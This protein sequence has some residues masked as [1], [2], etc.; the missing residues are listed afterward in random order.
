MRRSSYRILQQ[1]LEGTQSEEEEPLSLR[2]CCRSFQKQLDLALHKLNLVVA[3][4][5]IGQSNQYCEMPVDPFPLLPALLLKLKEE[6]LESDALLAGTKEEED[7]YY[8]TLPDPE[9]LQSQFM[10]FLVKTSADN[11]DKLVD[12]IFCKIMTNKLSDVCTWI[13]RKPNKL[14]LTEFFFIEIVTA[15]IYTKK[16]N[17]KPT[18]ELIFE[19]I[20][21]WLRRSSDR[22]KQDAAKEAACQRNKA[23]TKSQ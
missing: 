23:P 21:E 2:N 5:T 14:L 17:P 11:I 22:L 1:L 10:S 16:L 7:P 3:I 12:K 15:V 8:P 20:Q 9:K 19:T 4:L 13:G 6:L 18:D